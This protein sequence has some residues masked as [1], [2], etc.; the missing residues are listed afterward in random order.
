MKAYLYNI[1]LL[2]HSTQLFKI[3]QAI[4]SNNLIGQKDFFRTPRDML[5]PWLSILVCNAVA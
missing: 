2:V 3:I 4:A 5:I 1:K